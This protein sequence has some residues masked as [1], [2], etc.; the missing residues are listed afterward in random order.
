MFSVS[1]FGLDEAGADS[2]IT[3]FVCRQK[4]HLRMKTP[5]VSTVC[6]AKRIRDYL[7]S[8]AMHYRIKGIVLSNNVVLIN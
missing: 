3:F 1:R 4:S 6:V 7:K 8:Q 5:E 2:I